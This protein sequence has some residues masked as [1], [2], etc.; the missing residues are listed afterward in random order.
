MQDAIFNMVL[1]AL[2]NE[3]IGFLSLNGSKRFT[4][5]GMIKPSILEGLGCR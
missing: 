4:K 3:Q 2:K 1:R 5:R